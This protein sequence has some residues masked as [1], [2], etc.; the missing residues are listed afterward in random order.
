MTGWL[1]VRNRIEIALLT[2]LSYAG[3]FF[4]GTGMCMI[5]GITFGRMDR[6]MA[7]CLV[8][9]ALGISLYLYG[10]IFTE[11]KEKELKETEEVM[12]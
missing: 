5:G 1:P 7:D 12:E 2:V 11:K 4:F 3:V 9:V 10:Q 6:S 8:Y